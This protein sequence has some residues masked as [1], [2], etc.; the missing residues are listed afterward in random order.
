MGLCIKCKKTGTTYYLGYGGMFRLRSKVAEL[1][2][3]KFG[4][5]YDDIYKYFD[6]EREIAY[7]KLR[8]YTCKKHPMPLKVLDFLLA[9][10]TGAKI[11]YGC[12][13]EIYNGI[14]G[15]CEDF[16][17]GYAEQ[18]NPFTWNQ[19]VELLKECYDNKSDLVWA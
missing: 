19:F 17:I 1:F 8:E 7:K 14:K 3:K 5:L 12:C 4:E 18:K 11:T 10:D 6:K 13:K 16:T 9:P 15:K 2:D